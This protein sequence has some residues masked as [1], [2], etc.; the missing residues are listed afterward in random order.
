M[1]LSILLICFGHT[2][3]FMNWLSHIS[4]VFACYYRVSVIF[5]EKHDKMYLKHYENIT[6]LKFYTYNDIHDIYIT[7]LFQSLKMILFVIFTI[8]IY[9]LF[10]G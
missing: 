3:F 1:F 7:V 2:F 6:Q 5:P 4:L 8:Q 9:Y 10:S